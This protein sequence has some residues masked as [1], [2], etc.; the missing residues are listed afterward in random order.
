MFL[1]IIILELDAKR[2]PERIQ[3]RLHSFVRE[4]VAVSI[5][6]HD[7]SRQAI[8]RLCRFNSN[9][10][11]TILTYNSMTI[12][13]LA[14][15][16]ITIMVFAIIHLLTFYARYHELT[17]TAT[18][19][20]PVIN[21]FNCSE[22]TIHI[23]VLLFLIVLAVCRKE[24]QAAHVFHLQQFGVIEAD[25]QEREK[26]IE[27]VKHIE[28]DARLRTVGLQ[29]PIRPV[30]VRSCLLC[31]RTGLRGGL[32]V[33]V[34]VIVCIA[35]TGITVFRRRIGIAHID[36]RCLHLGNDYLLPVCIILYFLLYSILLGAR[37]SDTTARIRETE[38]LGRK[39]R[40]TAT[41]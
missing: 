28:A 41:L 11:H 23:R 20:E 29:H 32:T 30:V 27:E 26:T 38:S 12:I 6:Q 15:E 1:L 17:T 8:T 24:A 39:L 37:L 9:R 31:L 21:L 3:H 7:I 4:V 35:D 36:K 40:I 33:F 19:R 5:H 22:I 13:Y 10:L 16:R 14:V 18:R 34:D 2:G 25:T